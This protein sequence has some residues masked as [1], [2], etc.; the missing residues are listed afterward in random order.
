MGTVEGLIRQFNGQR[1][2]SLE[3][4][5]AVATNQAFPEFVLLLFLIITVAYRQTNQ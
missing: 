5:K 2:I 1:S 3:G 4:W